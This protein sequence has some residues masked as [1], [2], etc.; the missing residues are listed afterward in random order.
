VA[1]V[2]LVAQLFAGL[3]ALIHIVVFVWEVLLFHRPKVHRGIFRIPAEDV[4]TV[5]LWSVGVGFYN[6]FLGSGTIAG[7]IALNSGSVV[8]GRTLV[9]Y[10][11][12]FVALS[13]VVLFISDRLAL[14]RPKGSGIAGAIAQTG[15][16]M[17][18]LVAALG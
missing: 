2:N 17:V 9:L 8:A 16:A 10:T 7:L 5:R 11:C 1:A 6:L 15:P 12:A 3:V 13:G 4:P 18:V 14:S